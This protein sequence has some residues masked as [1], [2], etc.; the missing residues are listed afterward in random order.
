[1]GDS[2]TATRP[3]AGEYACFAV[4]G[5]YY[6]VKTSQVSGV[7][8]LPPVRKTPK[9][10]DFVEGVSC[11]RGR[12]VPVLDAARRFGLSSSSE[13][14]PDKLALLSVDDAAY[15]LIVDGLSFISEFSESA[16]EPVNPILAPADSS[17]FSAAALKD[18]RMVH[19]LDVGAFLFSG[20]AL[21]EKKQAV[22]EQY[23][24]DMAR[25]TKR[26]TKK[27]TRLF[28]CLDTGRQQYA[29][30]LRSLRKLLPVKDLREAA[31]GPDFLAG[32]VRF[33][34]RTFPT[35]DLGKLL[36]LPP[37][38]RSEKA[39]VAV[40]KASKHRFGILAEKAGEILALKEEQIKTPPASIV[41]DQ[42]H[43][44]G[45]AMIDGGRRLVP[46][47]DVDR[48]LGDREINQLE[49]VEDIQMEDIQGEDI[50]TAAQAEEKRAK[51]SAKKQEYLVFRVSGMEF[52]IRLGDLDQVVS[53]QEPKPVP[54]APSHVKGLLSAKGGLVSV[55]DLGRRLDLQ[56]EKQTPRR[57]VLVRID[58]EVVG[59]CADSVAEIREVPESDLTPA[60]GIVQGVDED[61][62]RH[63]IVI[64]DS[65]RAPMVLDM[66]KVAG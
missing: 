25:L 58:D 20:L 26:R 52:A 18:D 39:R 61:F 57:I 54:K 7:Y 37:G 6:G 29:I 34:D 51:S 24:A 31:A 44:D 64:K 36:G 17:F 43:I 5:E 59:V 27:K 19:L 2:H 55:I 40:V 45:V 14:K 15:G 35:V 63:L 60:P 53:Y 23:S 28:L 9:A 1:M 56:G 48:I 8:R 49:Q 50:A 32:T 62:V 47:L 11:L 21:D 38:P 4:R 30:P 66:K 33:G 10:P 46:L 16:I 22:F 65:D 42:G 41:S 12:I 3:L 13:K